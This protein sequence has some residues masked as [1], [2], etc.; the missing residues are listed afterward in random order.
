MPQNNQGQFNNHQQIPPQYQQGNSA[1]QYQQQSQNQFQNIP[2]Q[3]V[4]PNNFTPP[5]RRQGVNPQTG[6]RIPP[7]P[8]VPMPAQFENV[9]ENVRENFYNPVK[10]FFFTDPNKQKVL[11]STQDHLDIYDIRDDLLLLKNGDVALIIE[12]TAVNFQLLSGYEQNQKISAFSDLI[13]SL[14]FE[15]QVVIHTEP[16]D[17]RRYLN[18]LEESYRKIPSDKLK[19]Q[20]R[21]YIDFVKNLVVQNNVLQKR[22]FLVVPHRSGVITADQVNPLQ[23]AIDVVLGRKRVIEL[24]NADKLIEKAE[25]Q[26]LPKRDSLMKMLSR[27]GLGSKQLN[28]RELT[29]LFYSYYNPTNSF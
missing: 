20:M 9:T 5:Q 4:N 12:T 15:I 13:N 16:I 3:N 26:L 24:K 1:A 10:E 8:R 23:K 25:I 2:P 7:T 14:T 29:N 19:S 22:F 18:Y 28:N 21:I 11:A 27:M 17:M 6:F